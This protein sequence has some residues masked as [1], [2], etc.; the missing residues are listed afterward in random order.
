M[1]LRDTAVAD[2]KAILEDVDTGFGLAIEVTS[3]AQKVATLK[4]FTNDISTILDPETGQA[5]TGEAISVALPLGPVLAAFDDQVPEAIADASSKPW[6]VA[7]ESNT[8]KV[9]E[10]RPDRTLGIVVCLLEHYDSGES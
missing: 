9:R 2:A 3:P 8:Y 1:G 5:V 10:A 4:G 7:F 6:L